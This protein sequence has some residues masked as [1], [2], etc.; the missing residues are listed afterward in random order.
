MHPETASRSRANFGRFGP[1]VQHEKQYASLES[2]EDVFTIGLNH[3]VTL[4]A[5]RKAKGFKRRGPEPL[6][7]LGP[8]PVSGEMIKVMKGRYGTYVTDGA[9]NATIPGDGD[10]DS[11]TLADAAA[12][13]AARV[14]KRR[15][16]RRKRKRRRLP[17]KRRPNPRNKPNPKRT[18]NLPRKKQPAGKHPEPAE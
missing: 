2:P 4:I 10:A 14:A 11:V 18:K 7:E 5:E 6:K 16:A 15:P 17:Q 12:L 9:T 1:Y 8:D 3:A 13:I